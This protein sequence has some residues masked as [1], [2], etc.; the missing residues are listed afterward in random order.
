MM[1]L[2]AAAACVA[3]V[4]AGA[5]GATRGGA[6]RPLSGAADEAE[7]LG[8]LGAIE[9]LPGQARPCGAGVDTALL[10]RCLERGWFGAARELVTAC[11][12][13]GSAQ[14]DLA[15]VQ[16]R[17]GELRNQAGELSTLVQTT[18][19]KASRAGAGAG[20][21]TGASA[22]A[23]AGADAVVN[24]AFEWAQSATH[25][26]LGVKFAHKLDAP[27]CIDLVDQ[28]V[29]ITAAAV[30]LHATCKGKNKRFVLELALLEPIDAG[31]STWSMASVGRG[32]LTLVK[33]SPRVRWERLLQSATDKPRNMGTWWEL[34]EKYK[35]EVY[36]QP[37]PLEEAGEA[38]GEAAGE[39]AT[40]AAAE[41]AAVAAAQATAGEGESAATEAAAA[42]DSQA[43]P[44]AGKLEEQREELKKKAKQDSKRV[45]K[46]AKKA[47]KA[48]DAKGKERLAEQAARHQADKDEL[49]ASIK[50]EREAVAE[51]K[52]QRQEQIDA[53]LAKALAALDAPASATGG[54]AAG[55]GA[56]RSIS[57]ML[58]GG[59]APYSGAEPNEV[60]A[61]GGGRSGSGS[62]D[63]EL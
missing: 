61:G 25:V 57:S 24:P 55:Y 39:A 32:T 30:R 8:E 44:D 9:A 29:S 52:R 58:F 1:R 18:R 21:G 38:R 6:A 27:A 2:A 42:Q 28:D 34:H 43:G 11:A 26:Y 50:A 36:Q 47:L 54:W 7:L 40:E 19:A 63:K 16:A 45:N 53:T 20:A 22:G 15:A 48:S 41:A 31:A 33:V 12:E 14:V 35:D 59:S 60:A 51:T 56:M 10:L 37:S 46:E 3:C 13:A 49:E 23:G 62:S 5:V 17:A 4:A